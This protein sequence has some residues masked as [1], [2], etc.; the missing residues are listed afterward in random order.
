MPIYANARSKLRS[1]DSGSVT[2]LS[3]E[4]NVT[5]KTYEEHFPDNSVASR[6]DLGMASRSANPA[7]LVA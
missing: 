4:L 6:P 3:A 5:S 2:I 1:F 7:S